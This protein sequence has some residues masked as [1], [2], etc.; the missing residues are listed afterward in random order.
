MTTK[1]PT[2]LPVLSPGAHLAPEDGACLMEYVSV[3]AGEP[4]SD[5]PRCTDPMLATLARLVNDATSEGRRAALGSLAPELA[6]APRADAVHSAALVLSTLVRV[7]DAVGRSRRLDRHL[8][9]ARRHLRRTA[10][11]EPTAVWTR[12]LDLVHRH[13]P[14]PRRL[15]AAVAATEE[16]PGAARDDVLFDAL[17]SGP[18]TLRGRGGPVRVSPARSTDPALPA[19]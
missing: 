11:R 8:R 1:E 15:I 18:A 19:A 10:R 12:W 16:L 17:A 9:R 7:R 13:G 6:A 14:G 2:G 4:F 5:A 3:L